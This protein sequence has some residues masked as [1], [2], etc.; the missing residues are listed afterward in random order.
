MDVRSVLVHQLWLAHPYAGRCKEFL[1]KKKFTFLRAMQ[2]PCA[3]FCLG[4]Q[5]PKEVS[6]KMLRS[7][8]PFRPCA[9]TL[10]C[11]SICWKMQRFLVKDNLTFLRAMH[12]PCAPIYLDAQAPNQVLL[13]M[14]SS[15]CPLHHFPVH[16]GCAGCTSNNTNQVL[17][18]DS[19]SV[20]DVH[21]VLVHQLWLVHPHTGRCKD[22]LKKTPDL[23]ESNAVSL[24][25]LY[26]NEV[27]A[28]VVPV[29]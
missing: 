16:Q 26:E 23:F 10:T 13:K 6:L 8:C 29:C 3:P 15:G 17:Y 11:A 7:G 24:C 27:G 20:V 4:A 18:K 2:C 12:F 22:L 19:K 25:Y 21:S 1:K 9:S 14:L 5:A 28:Q